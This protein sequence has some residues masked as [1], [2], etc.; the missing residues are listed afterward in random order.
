VGTSRAG[1][2]HGWQPTAVEPTVAATAWQQL[3]QVPC[4]NVCASVTATTRAP[5]HRLAA[6][7]SR[8][9]RK[10]V[11]TGTWILWHC[12]HHANIMFKR[13]KRPSLNV[14]AQPH[15]DVKQN[16]MPPLSGQTKQGG[17]YC[18]ACETATNPTGKQAGQQASQPGK[19]SGTPAC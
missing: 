1:P 14:V 19:H 12:P 7:G 11:G 13:R 3:R 17:T 2:L 10:K 9:R 4:R 16:C 6:Q 5:P 15:T 18:K 8:L